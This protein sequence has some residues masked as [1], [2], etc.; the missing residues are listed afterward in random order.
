MSNSENID[1]Q[2]TIKHKFESWQSQYYRDVYSLFEKRDGQ[3]LVI[4]LE[5]WDDRFMLFLRNQFPRL[6][7][8]YETQ[9]SPSMLLTYSGDPIKNFKSYRSNQ[10]EAFLAQCIDDAKMGNLNQYYVWPD[11]I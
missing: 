4:A 9:T 3:R 1:L 10:I 5:Y 2:E 7:D 6:A 8:S 11:E